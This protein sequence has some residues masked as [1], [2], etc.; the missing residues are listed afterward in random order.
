MCSSAGILDCSAES[1]RWRSTTTVDRYPSIVQV[2]FY[3]SWLQ[4]WSQSCAGSIITSRYVVSAAHCFAGSSFRPALRRIRA[5]SSNRN[6][7]GVIVAVEA[8]FNHPSYGSYF[9][10]GDISVLRLTTP[11]EYS[12]VIQPTSIVAQNS[13]I[14]D[15]VPVVHAGWGTT[16]Q[17]GISSPILRDV[18]IYTVNNTLCTQRYAQ[19]GPAYRVTE[20][21]ICAGV[22]DVGGRDA[23]Q[24]DSGGPLYYGN[25][26]IGVVPWGYGCAH[27]VYPGISTSVVPY[28]NWIVSIAEN[29]V[30]TVEIKTKC[31]FLLK[32]LNQKP[33]VRQFSKKKAD[34]WGELVKS[35]N[36]T[37]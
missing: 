33:L 14:P 10:D 18:E 16:Q 19:L 8:V 32:S 37:N 20:N 24:G 13:A 11:L 3:N 15:N 26:L 25:I 27:T 4:S 21:M 31:V 17:G 29:T 7:G 30:L 9:Y 5:V 36:A 2:D 28:T 1:Y 23:C 6:A 34:T 12:S 22:L 35:Y